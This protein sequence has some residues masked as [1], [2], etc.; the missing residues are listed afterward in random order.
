MT[1]PPAFFFVHRSILLPTGLPCL[2]CSCNKKQQYICKPGKQL[3]SCLWLTWNIAEISMQW[4]WQ[5]TSHWLVV[6]LA[7]RGAWLYVKK[8]LTSSARLTSLHNCIFALQP[9]AIDWSG[10]QTQ[11]SSNIIKRLSCVTRPNDV[12]LYAHLLDLPKV[13]NKQEQGILYK[14]GFWLSLKIPNHQASLLTNRRMKFI[15]LRNLKS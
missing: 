1:S 7:L 9:L 5:E 4:L 12:L 11:A 15:F 14:A 6:F 2:Y 8:T 13:K 3:L 10:D